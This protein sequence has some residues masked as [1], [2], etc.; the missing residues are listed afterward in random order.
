MSSLNRSNIFLALFFLCCNLVVMVYFGLHYSKIEFWEGICFVHFLPLSY[1]LGP[2]LFFYVKHTVSSNKSFQLI[3]TIHLI[4]AIFVAIACSPFTTLP[5]DVKTKMAHEIVNFTEDYRLN[6]Y[7]VS[8]EQLLYARSIHV[9]LYAIISLVYFYWNKRILI[10]KFGVTPT[11]HVIIQRWF[12]TLIFLQVL[13]AVTSLGHMITLYTK[14]FL[15]LG[16]SSIELFSEKHFFRICGGGFFIQNFFLFLF[17]KI[18]YGNISYSVEIEEENT[19]QKI[20]SSFAKEIKLNIDS[21]EFEKS[22]QTY[23]EELPFIKKDFT[24]SQMSF[25]LKIP[26]RVLSNYFN[27]ELNKTF[28]EWKNDLRINYACELIDKG[29]AKKITIEAISSEV[30]FVSRSKFIDAFKTRKGLTPSV[31][32]KEKQD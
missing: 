25:D 12:F 15:I 8:F 21:Q 29:L 19:F 3:D 28:G 16:I 1:L 30:G 13:I 24:L 22:I 20:K 31:Y 17:P 7:W 6:F 18:L 5:L 9:I 10:Q 11:N 4:P 32:I 23:L 2:T 26:E 27:K 14:P